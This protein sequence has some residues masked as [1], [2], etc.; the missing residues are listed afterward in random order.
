M[1]GNTSTAESSGVD[2]QEQSNNAVATGND[3]KSI[4][5]V[6]QQKVIDLCA[7][8]RVIELREKEMAQREV[9]TYAA[10]SLMKLGFNEEQKELAFKLID[11]NDNNTCK[12]SIEIISQICEARALDIVNLRLKSSYIP[13]A[14]VSGNKSRIQPNT[15]EKEVQNLKSR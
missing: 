13:K 12:T 7:R 8:E 9:E 5:S 1:E 15:F 2:N 6:E 3:D 14:Y 4:L 11:F 10:E